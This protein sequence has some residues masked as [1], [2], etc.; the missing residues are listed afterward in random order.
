LRSWLGISVVRAAQPT[1]FVSDLP[2][3]FDAMSSLQRRLILASRM[4]GDWRIVNDQ[5]PVLAN[6][7]LVQAAGIER[8]QHPIA[9]F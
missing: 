2:N 3:R 6:Y 1:S 5:L 7:V 4:L 9:S 8:P